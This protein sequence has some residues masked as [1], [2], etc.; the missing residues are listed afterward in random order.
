MAEVMPE[1]LL[2]P[3]RAHFRQWLQENHSISGGVWLVFSKAGELRTLKASEALEEA[4]CFGWIDGLIKRLDDEKYLKMFS[5]RRKV[6]RW[7][8]VNRALAC[9]LIDSGQMTE[10]G[11][12]AVE[13]ARKKGTWDAPQRERVPDDQ[14]ELLTEALQ[15][16]DLALANFLEMAPSVRKAYTAFYLDAKR[17]ETRVRRLERIVKRLNA[18]KG[19]M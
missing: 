12:A 18:N 5:P 8:A 15:G 6:S 14:A 16:A 19:P 7:S 13:Q 11:L 10:H 2:F 9:R 1:Q 3:D 4:L 17:E